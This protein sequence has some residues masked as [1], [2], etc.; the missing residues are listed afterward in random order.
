MGGLSPLVLSSHFRSSESC[1]DGA[2]AGTAPHRPRPAFPQHLRPERLQLRTIAPRWHANDR[3]PTGSLRVG[4]QT[5]CTPN[6]ESVPLTAIP[7]WHACPPLPGSR[8]PQQV[9]RPLADSGRRFTPQ[10]TEPGRHP[11]LP[12]PAA[13]AQPDRQSWNASA[14]PPTEAPRPRHDDPP[15]FVDQRTQNL[16]ADLHL[17]RL[18]AGSHSHSRPRPPLDG[19]PAASP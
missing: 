12:S 18:P 7:N 15:P 17:G 5:T 3:T 19:N 10:Q 11:K 16:K 2:E 1:V 9:R 4:K 6:P 13:Q 14:S 8:R